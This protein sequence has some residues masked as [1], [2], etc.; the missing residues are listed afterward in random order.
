MKIWN[1]P[2][3]LLSLSVSLSASAAGPGGGPGG[4]GGGTQPGGNQPGGGG[5]SSTWTFD[6]FLASSAADSGVIVR[7][8]VVTGYASPT[9][10]A[11]SSSVTEIAAGAFAGCATLTSIDLSSTSITE[12]P[13]AAFA[14]CTALTTVKLPAACTSIGANAFADCTALASISCEGVETVGADAFRGCA[15]L[16]AVPGSATTLGEC[17]FAHSGVSAADVSGVSAAEGAF[18]GCESLVSAT[19]AE[20]A[21]LADALFS[22]CSALASVN[23]AD[24]AQFGVASM[25]GCDSLA[26][27]DFDEDAIL[28]DFAFSAGEATLET[29]LSGALPASRADSAFLGRAVSANVDGAVVRIEA[30][31]L[32]EWLLAEAQDATSSVAQPA[33]YNTADLETWLATPSNADAIVAFCYAAQIAADESFHPLDVSGE[34]FLFAAPDVGT[35]SAVSVTLVGSYVIGEDADWAAE[36]LVYDSAAEG[37]VAA[38]AEQTSCF[39]RLLLEKGW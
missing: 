33:S 3:A 25:A 34:T 2:L 24:A 37:Y 26:T 21:V 27:L 16:S 7:E 11:L 31:S 30:L 35:E 14:G 10:P 5:A 23:L 1:L 15:A 18:A 17:S 22:G 36:N 39:A 4:P 29:T 9:S 38:D 8:G 19:L 32:V 13:D 12:I 28:G 6:S 20:N